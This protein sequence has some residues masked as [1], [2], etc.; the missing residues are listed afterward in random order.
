[1]GPLK[2]S[3][4]RFEKVERL[5]ATGRSAV[6]ACKEVFG[7]DFLSALNQGRPLSPTWTFE[8]GQTDYV[9]VT[10]RSKKRVARIRAL[11]DEISLNLQRVS[12]LS[13]RHDSELRSYF[14]GVMRA[15]MR[16]YE[17]LLGEDV[18]MRAAFASMDSLLD[19]RKR[20]FADALKALQQGGLSTA[21]ALMIIYAV[22]VATGT[23][24]GVAASVGLFLF[25]IPVAQVA[26]LAV[27]GALLAALSR[28]KFTETN[29]MS[30]CIAVAYRLLE[31]QDKAAKEPAKVVARKVA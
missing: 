27:G 11:R 20:S 5:V 24:V 15:W 13:F 23:G 6:D 21:A 4:S 26:T 16:R 22:M 3:E 2:G 12:E 7:K 8:A 9:T 17:D 14:L 30:A 31:Q 28:V 1:L 29:A 19:G 18:D 10:V 25:G